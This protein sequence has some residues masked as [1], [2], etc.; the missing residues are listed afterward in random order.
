MTVGVGWQPRDPV[1]SLESSL[2][3]LSGLFPGA[4]RK[5]G[6]LRIHRLKAPISPGISWKTVSKQ[7]PQKLVVAGMGLCPESLLSHQLPALPD[8]SVQCKWMP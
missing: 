5:Q 8:P 7:C 1:S 2:L 3:W 4:E 6:L